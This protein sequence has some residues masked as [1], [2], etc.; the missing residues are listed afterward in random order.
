M[1][2]LLYVIDQAFSN[3]L[4]DKYQR[5]QKAFADCRVVT[6]SDVNFG[7]TS[8][9]WNSFVDLVVAAV[10]EEPAPLVIV[11]GHMGIFERHIAPRDIYKAECRVA[12]A[13]K[14]LRERFGGDVGA[15][16]VSG[17]HHVPDSQINNF[18]LDVR[19]LE[20]PR[21]F[22]RLRRIVEDGGG[23]LGR[24]SVLKHDVMR[25][26]ASVRLILQLEAEEENGGLGEAVIA[27]VEQAVETGRKR[28]AAI[29]A[30]DAVPPFVSAIGHAR[31]ILE[32]DVRQITSDPAAFHQWVDQLNDAL[33]GVRQEA[34]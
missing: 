33:D 29:D 14:V 3:G 30:T 1:Q 24:L 20:K 22:A 13:E 27:R 6:A 9:D 34:R 17:F 2:P 5:A 4:W 15:V 16:Y 7:T 25:P 28:L 12:A 19:E 18:L 11:L 21:S 10:R 32:V 26:F 23:P 31:T 8:E